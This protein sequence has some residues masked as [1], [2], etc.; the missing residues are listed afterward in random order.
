MKLAGQNIDLNDIRWTTSAIWLVAVNVLPIIGVLLLKWDV[1][2]LLW[3]YWIESAVLGLLNIPKILSCQGQDKNQSR[4]AGIGGRIYLA[5]FFAVHY[6]MFCMGHLIFLT[7]YFDTIPKLTEMFGGLTAMTGVWMSLIGLTVSHIISM[8]KNFYGKA[9]YVKRS[10]STQMFIPYGRIVIMHFVII[11]GGILV[12]AFGAPILALILLV[13]L[14]TIID[15]VS[16][17]VE[18]VLSTPKHA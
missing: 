13:L 15:L 14:K 17:N 9:E 12:Q 11:F 4:K 6:G 18:H 3:L 7:S 2:I 16:H 8:V 1:G 10:P 5:V